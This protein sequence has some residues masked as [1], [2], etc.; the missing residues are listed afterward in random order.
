V[1]HQEAH[2]M[3]FT[4]AFHIYP[5]A[6]IDATTDM[7]DEFFRH[8]RQLG[9]TRTTLPAVVEQYAA[10]P[11]T[12][13]SYMLMPRSH[14]NVS[15]NKYTMTLGG[16]WPGP[17]PRTLFFYDEACQMVFVEGECRPRMLR[18]YTRLHGRADFS[19]DIPWV[20]VEET[21]PDSYIRTDTVVRIRFTITATASTPFGLAYWDD[22]EGFDVV[23][24]QGAKHCRI[25][26]NQVAF[27]R[28]D[29][30][31]GVHQV[32]LELARNPRS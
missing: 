27:V 10:N 31:A 3:E 25:I 9:V 1:Q 4:P 32:H 19:V 13:P 15:L 22:L 26:A 6:D 2:E 5:Q 14:A 7:M 11:A 16:V 17:W 28:L 12:S 29:I 18:D 21:D 23:D 24:C 8:V 20:L 30:P